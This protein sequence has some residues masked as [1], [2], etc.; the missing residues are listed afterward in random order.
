MAVL[1]IT[2]DMSVVAEIADRVVVMW[3]A[4]SSRR[5]TTA[6]IFAHPQSAYTRA[7]L[8]AVP[9]ARLHGGRRPIPE[10]LSGASIR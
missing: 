5:R 3:Q 4:T 6:K 7:L 2:H 10:T 9:Q 1:F 8:A